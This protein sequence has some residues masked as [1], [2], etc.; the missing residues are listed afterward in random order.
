M[1]ISTITKMM[2][3]WLRS[4]QL[5]HSCSHYHYDKAMILIYPPSEYRHYFV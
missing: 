5:Y 4:D 2:A 1:L 3:S